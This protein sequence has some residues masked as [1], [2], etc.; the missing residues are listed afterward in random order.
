MSR[1]L[2]STGPQA[3]GIAL[4]LVLFVAAAAVLAGVALW[5]TEGLPPGVARVAYPVDY[6]D[7]IGRAAAEFDLDPYLV[8][9]VVKAESGFGARARSRAGARGLMQLMPNTAHWIVTRPDWEGPSEPDLE[10]P[11]D[12]VRLGCYY[13]RFLLD[14]FDGDVSVSLA[15]YNAG[16]TA[17][18]SWLQDSSSTSLAAG[19]IPFPETKAFVERVKHYEALYRRIYPYVFENRQK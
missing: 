16:H 19:D 9:A 18:A 13:L 15:A 12:N 3:G 7:E 2:R 4:A 5:L 17:V 6:L 14:R 1:R 8:L 11:L 10:D